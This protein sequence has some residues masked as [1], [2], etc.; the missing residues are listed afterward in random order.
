MDYLALARLPLRPFATLDISF[1]MNDALR[2]YLNVRVVFEDAHMKGPL[3]PGKTRVLDL[4][5]LLCS[6]AQHE[7]GTLERHYHIL[8]ILI[9]S[10]PFNSHD[11]ERLLRHLS[12]RH[13]NYAESMSQDPQFAISTAP[14]CNVDLWCALTG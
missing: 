7:G 9:I 8:V 4:S 1:D 11:A 3:I 14:L 5:H 12:Y 2:R 6:N 13:F 10:S